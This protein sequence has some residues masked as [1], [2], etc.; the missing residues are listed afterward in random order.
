MPFEKENRKSSS[1]LL[2]LKHA[3][4]WIEVGSNC[5]GA[6]CAVP[7]RLCQYQCRDH[8]YFVASPDQ[9]MHQSRKNLFGSANRDEWQGNQD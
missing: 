2:I 4:K 9:R 1:F 7:D 6:V 3:W 8:D 5:F